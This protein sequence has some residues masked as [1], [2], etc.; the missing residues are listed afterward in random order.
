MSVNYNNPAIYQ[1][2]QPNPTK[3][4]NIQPMH[5][6]ISYENQNNRLVWLAYFLLG[7]LNNLVY[8]VILSSAQSIAG[9]FDA[10]SYIGVVAWANVSFGMLIRLLNTF[11]WLDSSHNTR[12]I[13]CSVFSCISMIG[14]AVS[15]HINFISCILCIVVLGCC[16][17]LGESVVLGYMRL[18]ESNLVSAW[19]SGTGCAGVSGTLIYLLLY[20]GM[21]LQN[22]TVYMILMPS[23]IIYYMSW[24]YIYNKSKQ[25]KLLSN[26]LLNDEPGATGSDNSHLN[27]TAIDT[28]H[29]HSVSYSINSNDDELIVQRSNYQVLKYILS[30]ATQLSLVYLAEYVISIELASRS[31][32][33]SIHKSYSWWYVNA[34]EILAFCYQLGV[35]VARSSISYLQ[36]KRIYILT[37]L[38]AINLM[39]WLL[40][41]YTQFMPLYMQLIAMFYVGLLGGF[42]YLNVFTILMN[43]TKLT[44]S[45]RELAVNYTQIAINLG[46]V[47][48]S[49]IDIVIEKLLLRK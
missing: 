24:R 32:P 41:V 16:S 42:M 21:K 28:S 10:L 47:A 20:S 39:I 29:S 17:S 7:T 22:S 19:S 18:G 31:N 46:I 25:H 4:I 8:V 45:Q 37:L 3:L 38:Q 12:I 6:T 13:Y 36:I 27:I 15:V 5:N 26:E 40:H 14:L 49:I 33:L 23:S 30:T 34:Y 43:D 48:S 44:P 1:P 2:I 9:S 11:Y 35:L